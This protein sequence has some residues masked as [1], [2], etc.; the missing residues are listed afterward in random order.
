MTRT[1]AGDEDEEPDPRRIHSRSGW[2]A[3]L[4]TEL[5]DWEHIFTRHVPGFHLKGRPL[6]ILLSYRTCLSYNYIS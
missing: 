3:S 6:C 5:Y 2:A 1:F 4:L